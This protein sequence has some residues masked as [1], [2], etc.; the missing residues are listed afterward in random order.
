VFCDADLRVI[1]VVPA[2]RPWRFA[3]KRG[4]KVAIELSAGEAATRGLEAGARLRTADA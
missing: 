3:G 1:S 4:A 2:L